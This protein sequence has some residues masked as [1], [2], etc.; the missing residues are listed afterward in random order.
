M[1]IPVGKYRE[2]P[3]T[4]NRIFPTFILHQ[5]RVAVAFFMLN[6]AVLHHRRFR[7]AANDLLVQQF[8]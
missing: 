3:A 7:I 2:N 5:L 6:A 4:L 1:K 8:T